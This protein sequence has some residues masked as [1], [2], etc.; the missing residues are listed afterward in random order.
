VAGILKVS[1]YISLPRTT[2]GTS[3]YNSAISQVAGVEKPGECGCVCVCVCV[4]V[5]GT[6][7]GRER[8]EK[9]KK[10]G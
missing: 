6:C 7:Q 9:K 2:P 4:C 3:F 8:E 5:P 10:V 1:N